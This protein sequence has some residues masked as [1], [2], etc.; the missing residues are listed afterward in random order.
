MGGVADRLSFVTAAQTLDARACSGPLKIQL[1]DACG[2]A[3]LAPAT[4]TLTLSADSATTGFSGD[5]ACIG[6]PSAFQIPQGSS[7]LD[8][9]FSDS[10]PT[11][12]TITIGA[13]GLTSATQ[14]ETIACAATEKVCNANTCIPTADCCTDADCTAPQT[15]C[16]ASGACKLPACS[17]FVNNCSSYVPFTTPITF[18]GSPNFYSPKCMHSSSFQTVTYSGD[19]SFHP[20][21]QTCGPVE[22]TINGFGSTR[23]VQPSSWGTYGFSCK[24]HGATFE[25]SALQVP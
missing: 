19:F 8:V 17:G 10:A 22:L 6:A 15:V 20:L 4:V 21:E 11:M 16:G 18:P 24:T 3:V 13:A 9:F 23:T 25:G 5:A 2:A 12:T 7:S 14:T 1:S